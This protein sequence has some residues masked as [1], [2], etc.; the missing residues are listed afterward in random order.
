MPS[1]ST[2]TPASTAA[3]ANRLR[4]QRFHHGST[5]DA[6]HSSTIATVAAVATA[7]VPATSTGPGFGPKAMAVMISVAR[8]TSGQAMGTTATRPSSSAGAVRVP[9]GAAVTVGHA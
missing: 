2:A 1:T 8:S 4:I 7:A 3:A 6:G 9:T 5:T